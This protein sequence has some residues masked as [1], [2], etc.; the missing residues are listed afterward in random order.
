MIDAEV[1]KLLSAAET[2]V[3]STLRERRE[4]LV[5]LAEALL[6]EE[7]LDRAAMLALLG[8]TDRL[9]TRINPAAEVTEAPE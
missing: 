3:G 2:R 7:T 8:Q 4:Q 6:R 5:A 1:R 9:T